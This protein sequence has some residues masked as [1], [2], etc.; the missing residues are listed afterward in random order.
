MAK[1]ANIILGGKVAVTLI[2]HRYTAML[3]QRAGEGK[4]HLFSVCVLCP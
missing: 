1:V 3:T 2:K 4:T